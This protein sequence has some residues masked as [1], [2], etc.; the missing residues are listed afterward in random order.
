MHFSV[1]LLKRGNVSSQRVQSLARFCSLLAILGM[2]G[3]LPGPAAATPLATRTVL[4]NGAILLLAER[5]GVPMV[6]MNI[7][8][9]TGSTADPVN[10]AG[11]ANLTALLLTRGTQQHTA[12]ALAEALDFLGTSVSV[13]ADYETTTV[14]VT[15]LTKNLEASFGLL[16]EV[17]LHPTFPAEEFE[18]KRTEVLGTIRS[19]EEDPGWVANKAFQEKLYA[20]HPF[21]RLIDGEPDTL[22]AL[23]RADIVDFYRAYY[24]PNNAIIGI[25]GDLTQAQAQDVL[26][27]HLGGWQAAPLPSLTWPADP[28]PAA[29]HVLIDRP[30]SQA[31]IILGQPG[32][33][34]HNPDIYAIRVMNY[35][36]GAGGFGS[37][38]NERIREE[39]GLVYSVG[40]RFSSRKHAGPFRIVLQTKNASA[41][42][43]I[44]EAVGI[45]RR[46][47][48]EG[49][50]V[51][52][53]DAAK[54]YLVNSYPLGLVSNRQIAS[55]LPALEFYELGLDYPDRYPS[56]I[57]ALSLDQIKAVAKKYLH[58]DQLLQVVVAN[59]EQA[60]LTPPTPELPAEATAEPSQPRDHQS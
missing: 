17:L 47:I 27:R 38:L 49:A 14:L 10:K 15:S 11:V 41:K 1:R 9:K 39:L 32:V 29:A 12:Q 22:A 19:Q 20:E 23:S 42:Q 3:L 8:L 51:A 16:A 53:F 45:M 24:R 21:G 18:R 57:Q 43:A 7:T 2:A 35:I 26:T 55:L 4:D 40:S 37:R 31:N 28:A 52:E 58:P 33:A 13:S 50:T 44:E 48:E 25:A 6:V 54:A 56:I 46:Y 36:L 59:L 34:R 5:P 60:E 30:V